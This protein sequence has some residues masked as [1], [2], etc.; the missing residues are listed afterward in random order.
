MRLLEALLSRRARPVT[1][2][3][4][5]ARPAPRRAGFWKCLIR[6]LAACVA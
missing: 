3:R 5:P 4:P 2:P 6:S 1:P